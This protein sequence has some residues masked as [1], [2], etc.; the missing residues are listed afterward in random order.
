MS[1]ILRKGGERGGRKLVRHR[2]IQKSDRGVRFNIQ[3]KRTALIRRI[4]ENTRLHESCC[5]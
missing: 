3:K 5:A 2:H 4:R 1:K